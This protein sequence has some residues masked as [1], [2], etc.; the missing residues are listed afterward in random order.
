MHC[1]SLFLEGLPYPRLMFV[2]IV[3]VWQNWS[4]P[5]AGICTF[6]LFYCSVSL[7][8]HFAGVYLPY[9]GPW[10]AWCFSER[11]IIYENWGEWMGGFA[12]HRRGSYASS[13]GD[14]WWT[15]WVARM[16]RVLY[17]ST[18][19]KIFSQE[20]DELRTQTIASE[21]QTFSQRKNKPS[22]SEQWLGEVTNKTLSMPQA[23]P[24]V[25]GIKITLE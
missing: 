19:F 2:K 20:Q 10:R 7:R 6:C 1:V 18:D 25:D 24:L 13:H 17:T 3:L 5:I 8:K 22:R 12:S 9:F 23:N 4:E 11:R 15:L 14:S 21:T 16:S